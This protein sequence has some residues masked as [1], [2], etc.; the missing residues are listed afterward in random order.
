MHRF[1]SPD[2]ERE[3]NA[4]ASAFLMPAKDIR[5][6][7]LGRQI[8]L[9]L[10]GALKPEWRVSMQ[11]LLMRAASL[12]MLSLGQQQYLWKQINARG[13]RLRE[14]PQFDISEE[15]PT[16]LPRVLDVHKTA[17]GYSDTDLFKMLRIDPAEM[18]AMYDIGK[19]PRERPRI[20]LIT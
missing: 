4:F 1:P 19:D 16:I 7:F 3:A 2:M 10:L 15:R 12:G 11:A 6:A 18:R 13:F 14:P 8:T 20:T 5:S 17:L 9:A